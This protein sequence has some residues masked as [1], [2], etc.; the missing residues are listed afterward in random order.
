MLFCYDIEQFE[1]ILTKHFSTYSKK[2]LTLNDCYTNWLIKY[3]RKNEKPKNLLVT[4]YLKRKKTNK[5]SEDLKLFTLLQFLTF[6]RTKNYTKLQIYDQTYFLIQFTLKE[7]IQFLGVK[8]IN[9]YQRNKF[10]NLFYSFQKTEP[11]INYF[12]ESH[13]QSILS[14]PYLD[15]QKQGN[16]WIV[17][18]AISQLLYDYDYPFSF[19]YTFLIY[20]NIYEL[21][22]K[23]KLIEAIAIIPL[24]KVFYVEVFLEQFNISTSKRAIIKNHILKVFNQLQIDGIIKNHYILIKKSQQIQEVATLIQLLVGQTNT[25]YFYENI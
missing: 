15:I 13:F 7:Y 11:L 2:V 3:L 1:K 16:S 12:T 23:L 17:K 24:K 25:I 18:I 4:S 22:I 6:S 5:F 21:R 14:F 19:P 9:Q 8:T 20:K 10:I